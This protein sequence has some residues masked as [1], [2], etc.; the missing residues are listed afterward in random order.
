M[1]DKYHAVEIIPNL[2]LG[3]YRAAKD[4]KFFKDNRIK[5]VINVTPNIINIIQGIKILRIPIN[6]IEDHV[7]FLKPYIPW[8]CLYIH[9]VL[10]SDNSVLVHCKRGHRRSAT[11]IVAYLMSIGWSLCK[12]IKHVKKL[13]PNAF[14]CGTYIVKVLLGNTKIPRCIKNIASACRSDT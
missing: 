8:I 9:G 12:S 4:N 2:W 6:N 13:R 14:R 7:A 5:Y 10:Q 3:D 11:I 1:R